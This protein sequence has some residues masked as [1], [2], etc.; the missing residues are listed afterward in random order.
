[1]PFLGIFV[2]SLIPLPRVSV[3]AALIDPIL[4]H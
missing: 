1:M 4:T 2:S 3:F